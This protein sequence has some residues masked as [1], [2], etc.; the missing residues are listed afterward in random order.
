MNIFVQEYKRNSIKIT[1]TTT[2]HSQ[3]ARNTGA[4]ALSRGV[5]LSF[6]HLCI[7]L[8]HNI[9]NMSSS[10]LLYFFLFT[11]I[12][13][14]VKDFFKY[15]TNKS[16]YLHKVFEFFFLMLCRWAQEREKTETRNFIWKRDLVS[17]LTNSGFFY[18]MFFYYSLN[19]WKKYDKKKQFRKPFYEIS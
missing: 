1:N 16:F 2:I 11:E 19:Q 5:K 18:F 14:F 17:E 10:D 12:R 7:C 6:F 8:I 4:W 15:I 9:I 3:L 13:N